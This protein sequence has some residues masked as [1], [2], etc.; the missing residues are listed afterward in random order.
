MHVLVGYFLGRWHAPF[1]DS[2]SFESYVGILRWRPRPTLILSP[3]PA[4]LTDLLQQRLSR[5]NVYPLAVRWEVF[6]R[7][8]LGIT[9]PLG[10]TAPIWCDQQLKEFNHA[11]CR[12]LDAREAV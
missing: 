5:G 6:S 3:S 9:G 7:V 1:H 12:E 8:V 2:E 11:Y 10:G 4:E